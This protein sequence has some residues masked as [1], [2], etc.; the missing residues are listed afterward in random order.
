MMTRACPPRRA[1]LLEAIQ[2]RVCVAMESTDPDKKTT[3]RIIAIE[4]LEL[5]EREFHPPDN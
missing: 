4:I 5:I 2:N 1:D 3:S